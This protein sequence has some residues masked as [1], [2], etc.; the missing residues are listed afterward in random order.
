MFSLLL[1]AC[2]LL[3]RLHCIP[4]SSRVFSSLSDVFARVFF[5]SR[6]L[7]LHALYLTAE[8]YVLQWLINVI[9]NYNV[10]PLWLGI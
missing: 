3:P 8:L 5:S 4:L 6:C 1:A 10:Q 7:P 2:S 9:Y